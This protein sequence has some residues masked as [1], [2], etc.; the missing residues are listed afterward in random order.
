[1]IQRDFLLVGKVSQVTGSLRVIGFGMAKA[2]AH[3]GPHL[4]GC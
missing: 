4:A 2:L 1:M 3:A